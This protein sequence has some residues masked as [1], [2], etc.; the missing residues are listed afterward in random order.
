MKVCTDSCVFGSSIEVEGAKSILDIGSGTGLLSL[1]VA[2]RTPS[3][4]IALEPDNGAFLQ[5][6]RNVNGS[7]FK[8]IT[9][10]N[11][12]LQE[13][14]SST[15]NKHDLILC[16]PPF[17]SNYLKSADKKYNSATHD[18]TL[19][20]SELASCAKKLLA[21]DGDFWILLPIYEFEIFVNHAH[22]SQLFLNKK[23]T[24]FDNPKAKPIRNIGVFKHSQSRLTNSDLY[25]KSED[26][27]YSEQFQSLLSDYYLIF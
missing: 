13:Y 15:S 17:Y 18:D 24:V 16:N 20:L 23:I 11:Q 10:L 22:G 1:M 4:I 9:V 27:V 8:N 26:N 3:P 2:Q 7:P 5:S 21:N 6:V 14:T 19:S 25:I 12:P